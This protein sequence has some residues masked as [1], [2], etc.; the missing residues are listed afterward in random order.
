MTWGNRREGAIIFFNI[1]RRNH[2][3]YARLLFFAGVRRLGQL[4]NA[5]SAV[6]PRFTSTMLRV[7]DDCALV[8]G[9]AL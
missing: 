5:L 2:S 1:L 3:V 9:Y 6:R 4:G 8:A 7:I